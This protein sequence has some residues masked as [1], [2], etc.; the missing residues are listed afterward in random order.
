M[1]HDMHDWRDGKVTFKG[2]LWMA[3]ALARDKQFAYFQDA[4]AFWIAH[5]ISLTS[6]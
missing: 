2:A 1:M 6:K 3:R 4:Y 5:A